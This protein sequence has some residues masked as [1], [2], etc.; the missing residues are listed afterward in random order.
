MDT[1]GRFGARAA[2]LGLALAAAGCGDEVDRPDRSLRFQ[3]HRLECDLP[4]LGALLT[5]DALGTCDLDVAEDRTVSG[6]CR[7][8]LGGQ[9]HTLVLVYWVPF[10]GERMEVAR[11]SVYV[12]FT[13]E[14]RSVVPIDFSGAPLSY[15]DD[16]RDGRPNLTELCLGQD[17]TDPMG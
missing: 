15:P 17:P 5:V 1:V 13:D 10:G 16:D 3:S 6:A 2:A 11:A 7:G 9:A 12:D 14:E 4:E 8:M